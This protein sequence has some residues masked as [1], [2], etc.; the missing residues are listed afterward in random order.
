MTIF[1]EE[2]WFLN[3]KSPN[4]GFSFLGISNFINSYFS[5]VFKINL[6][7]N[8]TYYYFNFHDFVVQQFNL[9]SMLWS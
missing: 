4:I 2:I 7:K 3:A 1:I 8:E 6:N 9:S 5:I